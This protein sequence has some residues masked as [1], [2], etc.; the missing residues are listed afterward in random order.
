[1]GSAK[2]TELEEEEELKWKKEDREMREFRLRLMK[3]MVVSEQ[4][5]SDFDEGKKVCLLWERRDNF[6]RRKKRLKYNERKCS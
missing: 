1:M 5:I 6:E 2:R 3:E 4:E